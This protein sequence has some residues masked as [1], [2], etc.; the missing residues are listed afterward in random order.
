MTFVCGLV[1]HLGLSLKAKSAGLCAIRPAS[2]IILVK[3]A[4][5][6]AAST[7]SRL[8]GVFNGNL[9]LGI[10]RNDLVKWHVDSYTIWEIPEQFATPALA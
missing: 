4:P 5:S 1:K 6:P 2:L 7:K 3:Y 10:L 8:C 9:N